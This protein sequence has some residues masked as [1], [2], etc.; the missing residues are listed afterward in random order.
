MSF[1]G[2]A[3][4]MDRY[5]DVL[6]QILQD[7][8]DQFDAG[9]PE[10]T[11]TFDTLKLRSGMTKML[12]EDL[13]KRGLIVTEVDDGGFSSVGKISVRRRGGQSKH[14]ASPNRTESEPPRTASPPQSPQSSTADWWAS[15]AEPPGHAA[16]PRQSDPVRPPAPNPAPP[17]SGS[18]P[19]WS[20]PVQPKTTEEGA[21]AALVAG[22]MGF[23]CCPLVSPFAIYQGNRVRN[24]PENPSRHL[25]SI[26]Y[27]LGIV[28][29][30][31]WTIAAIYQAG[32]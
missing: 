17:A 2:K 14:T 9:V 4:G 21:Q 15:S 1:I 30:V 29:A 32:T 6:D 8:A 16:A 31:V 19:Y 5:N 25:G 22:I 28:G 24:D 12:S 26:A 27:V 13:R 20:E 10:A 7:F 18:S 23:V 3:T 11:A